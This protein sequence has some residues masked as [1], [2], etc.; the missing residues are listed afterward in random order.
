LHHLA[1]LGGATP[2]VKGLEQIAFVTMPGLGVEFAAMDTAMTVDGADVMD[3]A[4]TMGTEDTLKDLTES[5]AN[6]LKKIEDILASDSD[7]ETKKTRCQLACSDMNVECMNAMDMHWTFVEKLE[8]IEEHSEEKMAE[9]TEKKGWL[10][11]I[12]QSLF[13]KKEQQM[14]KQKEQEF[15]SQIDILTKANTDL[16]AK[17]TEFTDKEAVQ[18]KAVADA[19]VKAENDAK[20]SEVKT[21]CD[22]KITEGKMTPAMR[23]VDEP[24]MATLIA[25]PEALKSFQEKYTAQVV[26]LGEVKIVEQQDHSDKRPH[27]IKA[28]EKYVKDHPKEFAGIAA[29][30]AINRAVYLRSMG[31]IKFED[32]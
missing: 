26:P 12:T 24:L 28:A 5:C 18:A 19:I 23:I 8:N 9:M 10:V 7:Y 30:D 21:F 13:N 6:F 3:E 11:R 32:K 31:H 20:V 15:Q 16:T 22:Q 4:E 25:T 2:A 17:V 1:F 29:A 14:D 27:V